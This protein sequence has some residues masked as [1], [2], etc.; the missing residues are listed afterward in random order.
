MN[1]TQTDRAIP[2]LGP[3]LYAEWRAADIGV[4]TDRLERAQIMELA[5]NVAGLRAL[6]VG[7]GD[8]ELALELWERGAEV[9]GVDASLEMIEAA[10]VRAKSRT[11]P[12][13]FEVGAAEQL[14]FESER[15]DIIVAVTILCFVQ[16]AVP[17]FREMARVLRPGGR[18]IIGE[19]GKWSSWAAARR[20]RAWGG[21]ALW[22][23]ARFRTQRELRSLAEN[24]GL[25]VATVRGSVYYPSWGFAAPL[26]AR[27]DPALGRLT[28]IGAAFIALSAV[29][30]RV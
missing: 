14:P 26:C 27:W 29:K 1:E 20:I 30:R 17:V 25:S 5:G 11:A 13:A 23:R 9:T 24:A 4:I 22:R 12:I 8:G 6:D 18:L 15:F 16:N 28:T 2:G 21:S 19:L 10:R 3:G 7:C